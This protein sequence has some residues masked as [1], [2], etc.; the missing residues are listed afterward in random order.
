MSD[1]TAALRMLQGSFSTAIRQIDYPIHK[2]QPNPAHGKFT[3]VGSIPES[4]YDAA[5]GKSLKYDSEQQAVDAAIA[6]G[7]TRIQRC[8]CSFVVIA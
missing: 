4:C 7:A 5:A 1:M 6:G 3:F 8:D 2:G